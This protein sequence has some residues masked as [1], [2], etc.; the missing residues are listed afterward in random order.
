M[1]AMTKPYLFVLL[2]LALCLTACNQAARQ[3]AGDEAIEA[4]EVWA[5]NW[6]G[7]WSIEFENAPVDGPLVAEV[8]HAADGRLRIETLEAPTAALNGLTLVNTGQTVWFYDLRQNRA[9]SGSAELERIPIASDGLAVMA[10]MLAEVPTAAVVSARADALESG[11]A[12]RLSLITQRGDRA[13]L[14][15]HNRSGLPAGL[16]LK[17]R[18]WGDVTLTSR[19]LEA[20][21][22]LADALFEFEPPADAEIL[23]R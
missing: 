2:P 12:K 15:V 18:Q 14:W 21:S 22:S 1:R 16:D 3:Q 17:S 19:S 5:G 10:W 4:Q 9:E 6:H 23:F 8:W 7:V 20:P 13:E 11:P